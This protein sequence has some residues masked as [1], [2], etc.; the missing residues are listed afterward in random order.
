[1]L[2][3]S[4]AQ[5]GGRAVVHA[6]ADVPHDRAPPDD[7]A[8]LCRKAR[9]R[10]RAEPRPRSSGWRADFVAD[11][12][13]QFEAAKSYRPNKADWLEG[14]WA[15][16]EPA[17][18]LTR[19]DRRGDTGRAARD[20]ARRSG[21]A[22]VTVPEGFHLN[23]KMARQLEAKRAAIESGEGI[24]WATAEA[25][26]IGTLCAE[27]TH[28]RLSGQDSGRGTFSHRHA[29]LVDQETEERYVP[30]NHISEGQAPFEIIDSPL[31]EAAA[32]GFGSRYTRSCTRGPGALGGAIR[33]IGQ[34][35]AQVLIDQFVAASGGPNGGT[36]ACARAAAA[37]H[38]YEGQGA[39]H[40]SARLK[41]FLQLFAEG[42]L[43]LVPTRRPLRST[44]ICCG[45][46]GDSPGVRSPAV[47]RD[48]PEESSPPSG[49]RVIARPAGGHGVF[50]PVLDERWLVTVL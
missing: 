49:G 4:R 28:V 12:E 3:A 37:P 27:G 42:N 24:D 21:A 32:V 35:V 26:A 6:A 34:I 41:Q 9:R 45:N 38:G 44:S 5:R 11:L 7:A 25:L 22:L 46:R 18:D 15:G 19:D 40:S 29:V 48:D 2:P 17:P 30:I 23:R 36:G 14:A 31:S 8:D 16:L 33:G 50:K 39:E 10:G 1:M 20:A 43:M 13:A 47:G